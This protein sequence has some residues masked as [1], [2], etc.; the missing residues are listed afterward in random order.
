MSL[1]RGAGLPLSALG[2]LKAAPSLTAVASAHMWHPPKEG[3]TRSGRHAQAHALADVMGVAAE[4]RDAFVQSFLTLEQAAGDEPPPPLPPGPRHQTPPHRASVEGAGAAARP[5]RSL[6]GGVDAGVARLRTSLSHG[7]GSGGNGGGKHGGA[8]DAGITAGV[9]DL[10]WLTA[11]TQGSEYHRPEFGGRVSG[12]SVGGASP[13]AAG[14]ALH[15]LL[16]PS[17]YAAAG[18]RRLSGEPSAHAPN[19]GQHPHQHHQVVVGHEP[20]GAPGHMQHPHPPDA[21]RPRDMR[22]PGAA[23]QAGDNVGGSSVAGARPPSVGQLK[24]GRSRGTAAATRLGTPADAIR[25]ACKAAATRSSVDLART[26]ITKES[27]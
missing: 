25:S 7:G 14:R 3:L 16:A 22:T 17:L 26:S 2:S 9:R 19:V 4:R 1:C 6:T 15:D 10:A 13:A 21:P 11:A 5:A 24:G 23:P 8:A 12:T 18:G 20:H 27:E